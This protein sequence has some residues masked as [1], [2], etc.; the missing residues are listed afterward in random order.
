MHRL[1][2]TL[3]ICLLLV[4]SVT[5]AQQPTSDE[6]QTVEAQFGYDV[7]RQAKERAERESETTSEQASEQES[8]SASTEKPEVV[9]NDTI[10][11]EPFGPPI[12]AAK[13]IK[14][15]HRG[16]PAYVPEHTAEGVAMAHAFNVDFIEQDVV[17]TRDSIPV[18][19]HDI[20]LDHISNVAKV[21]PQ[22]TRPDGH[23]YVMDFSLDELRQLRLNE[24]VVFRKPEQPK[25]EE[26]AESEAAESEIDST[27][28]AG[29]A[30]QLQSMEE[31]VEQIA[32]DEAKQRKHHYANKIAEPK[33]PER[34]P[35]Q[36][37]RFGIMTLAEQLDLIHGLN[38]SRGKDTGVYIELKS[39][40]WHQQQG[41]DL[42]AQVMTVLARHGYDDDPMPTR[43]FL[44]S[45]DPEDLRRWHREFRT[46]ATMVQLIGE[47][48]WNEASVDYSSMRTSAG[49]EATANQA[50]AIGVW[51]PHVISGVDDEGNPRYTD[52]V[53]NAHK[54]G[55]KVHVY[56][57]RADDLPDF[58]PDYETLRT[59]LLDAGIDG[60]FTDAPDL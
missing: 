37:G 29:S 18:V 8:E 53:K 14:I 13:P 48:S 20:R 58:A 43:I 45:F 51:V 7:A 17:L 46:R 47:N 49:L 57:L 12:P 35:V 31:S 41:Y 44:Q 39:S 5:L 9:E 32:K 55:L 16:A 38:Q 34:F 40:R 30:E 11:G 2:Q 15:A 6:P 28:T 52:L 22:R 42:M 10:I 27:E 36:Q 3:S 21:F 1:L 50:H 59:W 19:L 60:Y 4:S 23:F 26:E 33:Y 25:A 56:T 54:A 24:R